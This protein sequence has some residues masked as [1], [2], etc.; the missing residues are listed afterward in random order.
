MK[1]Q[2]A[3]C[4]ILLLSSS[5]TYSDE[6]S[7]KWKEGFSGNA[8]LLFGV[9]QSDS[10]ADSGNKKLN[11]L[12]DKGEAKTEGFIYPIAASNV[13]Y[14][15][16]GGNHQ[17]FLG[18]SNAD[19]ALG[20][21]HFELGYGQYINKI[22][23][24]KV[25]YVPGLLKS[26]TWEDPFLV[27]SNREETDQRIQGI[28]LQYQEIFDTGLGFELAAGQ[29]KIDDELSAS[30]FSPTIQ[31]ELNRESDIYYSEL[32]YLT[33]LSPKLFLRS[34]LAYLRQNA[35]GNAMS[36]DTYTGQLAVV[37]KFDRSALTISFKYQYANFD[38]THPI[39]LEK[40]ENDIVGIVST[41]TYDDI[42]GWPGVGV[43]VMGGFTEKVSN[44]DF[45]EGSSWILA[46]GVRYVF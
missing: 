28:R 27:G 3:L 31:S 30:Q 7:G 15:F 5:T 8:M 41:Y 32:S 20:R 6:M 25:S 1:I 4:V 44:L 10:L 43:A 23:I 29:R 2:H 17:L 24:F 46:S 12:D 33:P 26:T 18:T 39:F 36:S 21:P 11:S 38:D 14:T 16:S 13:N 35:K 9:T 45:Y 19:I 40:Q 34:S 22:G 42:F 37:Q